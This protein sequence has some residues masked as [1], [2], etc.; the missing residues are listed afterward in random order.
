MLKIQSDDN[1]T[2]LLQSL[3]IRNDEFTL[4]IKFIFS[5]FNDL[6]LIKLL[7]LLEVTDVE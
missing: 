7:S 3:K 2:Q 5:D 6:D 1:F 4:I